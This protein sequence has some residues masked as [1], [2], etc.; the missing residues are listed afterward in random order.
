MTDLPCNRPVVVVVGDPGLEHR[1]LQ[2]PHVDHIR[3]TEDFLEELQSLP[4]SGHRTADSLTERMVRMRGESMRANPALKT[5]D[6]P[7][8]LRRWRITDRVS[9][10]RLVLIPQ[11]A[12]HLVSFSIRPH[13]GL[14]L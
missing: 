1:G 5:S 2:S 4:V 6:M 13:C 8:C 11:F 7:D 12:V 14:D 9:G 10:L 3:A